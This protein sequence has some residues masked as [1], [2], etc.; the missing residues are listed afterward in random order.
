[1]DADQI[2]NEMQSLAG[3]NDPEKRRRF[4]QLQSQ[5]MDLNEG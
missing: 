3:T 5:W 4:E 1:L 2:Y